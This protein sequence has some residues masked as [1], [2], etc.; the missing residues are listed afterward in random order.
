ML[1]AITLPNY[2]LYY[3]FSFRLTVMERI[4]ELAILTSTKLY[5]DHVMLN[6]N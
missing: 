6:Y 1:L 5:Q 2:G 3:S 4:F